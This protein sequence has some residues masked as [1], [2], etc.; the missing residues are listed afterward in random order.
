[1]KRA[2]L[3]FDRARPTLVAAAVCAAALLLAWFANRQVPM[4]TWL[5][6]PYA[7]FWVATILWV[8]CCASVGHAALRLLP[9]LGL[10]FRERLLFDLAIGR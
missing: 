8:I 4:G 2:R 10:P 9:A 3:L 7:A 6:W 5:L 1:M